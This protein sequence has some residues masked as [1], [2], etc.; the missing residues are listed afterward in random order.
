MGRGERE[1]TVEFVL[2][3]LEVWQ[4]C[5]DNEAAKRVPNEAN[6]RQTSDWTELLD[7]SLYFVGQSLAHFE[8]I[9]LSVILVA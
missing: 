4:R 3:L 2:E 1:V 6:A 5:S 8:N 9:A 7:V